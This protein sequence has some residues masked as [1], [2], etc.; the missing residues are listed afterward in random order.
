MNLESLASLS[1][2]ATQ[3]TDRESE[4]KKPHAPSTAKAKGSSKALVSRE[5]ERETEPPHL[6]LN[7]IFRILSLFFLLLSAPV[8]LASR[9]SPPTA[10]RA[11]KHPS[12]LKRVCENSTVA[13]DSVAVGQD[14]NEGSPRV[15]LSLSRARHDSRL[16]VCLEFDLELVVLLRVLDEQ[17]LDLGLFPK[18][19]SRF[20]H[21]FLNV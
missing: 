12:L 9:A 2:S 7:D 15:S 14:D 11:W 19:L 1:D 4:N 10:A 5:R 16:D 17:L 20:F 6:F 18:R 13:Q 21:P 3:Q 8:G